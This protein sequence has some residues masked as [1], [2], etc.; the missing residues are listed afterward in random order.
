MVWSGELFFSNKLR[1]YEQYAEFFEYD[2]QS[3][4]TNNEGMGDTPEMDKTQTTIR[5]YFALTL[6]LAQDDVTKIQQIDNQPLY[7]CLN[8]SAL[9]KERYMKQKEEIDK[10][11]SQTNN[12]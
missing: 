12:L 9:F 11:K 3:K 7:L 8:T 10:I 6:Q 5:F 1:V 2:A 4:S